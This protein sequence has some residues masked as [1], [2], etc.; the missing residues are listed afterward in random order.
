MSVT[1]ADLNERI[2]E[3]YALDA[4][5]EELKRTLIEPKRKRLEDL[6]NLILQT[7]A[8]HDMSSYKSPNGTVVRSLRYSVRTPKS[9][10]E[11]TAFFEWLNRAKGREVY[12]NYV[13]INS[14]SLNAFY[15][16][17]MEAAKESG[18]FDFKIP[19]L[20]EPEASPVLSRRKK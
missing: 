1:L 14:Q 10:E 6:E 8:D 3:A 20:A 5:L 11:K 18:D 12:W 17:E 7:L 19:G 16:A 15:K 13:T 2:A 4:E 9:L